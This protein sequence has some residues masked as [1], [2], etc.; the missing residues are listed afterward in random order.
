MQDRIFTLF[1]T[2][3]HRHLAVSALTHYCKLRK[4]LLISLLAESGVLGARKALKC[5]GQGMVEFSSTRVEE[6]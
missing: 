3:C 6:H 1:S 2:P 4:G 5:A